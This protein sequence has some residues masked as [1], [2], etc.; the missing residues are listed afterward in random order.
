MDWNFDIGAA[1]RGRTERVEV[2]G[3]PAKSFFVPDR[4]ILATKCGKVTASHWILNEQRWEMLAVGEEP[5]A[6]QPWPVHP[7]VA[8]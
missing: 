5:L 3:K 6:W 4:V 2:A 1:P 8:A 7:E